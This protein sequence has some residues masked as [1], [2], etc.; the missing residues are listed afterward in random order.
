MG[1]IAD[2]LA[3]TVRAETHRLVQDELHRIGLR[4]INRNSTDLLSQTQPVG[5]PVN[6][7]DL[8]RTLNTRGQGCHQSHRTGTVNHHRIPWN[9]AGHLG[10]MIARGED[11]REHHVVVLFLFRVL[12]QAQAIMVSVWHP[13][14]FSLAP[15]EGSHAGETVCGT[16][17]C[18]IG[19]VGQ[20]VVGVTAFA[21]LAE[22]A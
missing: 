6:D 13:K 15:A 5:V 21:V 4:I 2:A 9:H 16:P 3:T 1:L 7:H 22:P 20:A 10:G 17:R 12:S 14:Q 11:V 18:R 19:L 8:R